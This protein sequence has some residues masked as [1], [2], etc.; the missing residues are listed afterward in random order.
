VGLPYTLNVDQ[1]TGRNEIRLDDS[2]G[3]DSG[4]INSQTKGEILDPG[5][6]N[7]SSSFHVA[8]S[9]RPGDS[10]S[11]HEST[12]V[13]FKSGTIYTTATEIP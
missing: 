10:T 5:L 7:D 11:C 4:P 13:L 2:R 6:D 9:L 1:V 8:S 12:R 3:S